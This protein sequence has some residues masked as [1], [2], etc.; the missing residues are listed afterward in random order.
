MH[1]IQGVRVGVVVLRLT[2]GV[3]AVT[4]VVVVIAA[5]RTTE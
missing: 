2:A 1:C 4:V 5:N 3:V